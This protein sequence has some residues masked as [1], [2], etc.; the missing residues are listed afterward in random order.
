MR[1]LNSVMWREDPDVHFPDRLLVPL[2]SRILGETASFAFLLE[3]QDRA[4]AAIRWPRRTS[5]SGVPPFLFFRSVR[6]IFSSLLGKQW[7][8]VSGL[9][10]NLYE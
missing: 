8:K 5:L 4:R 3:P 6:F 1:R 2:P 10:D 7:K 9:G